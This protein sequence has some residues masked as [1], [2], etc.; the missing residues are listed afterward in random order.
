[1]GTR[2][3]KLGINRIE[4]CYLHADSMQRRRDC[5][6]EED[7]RK[8]RGKEAKRKRRYIEVNGRVQR[9]RNDDIFFLPSGSDVEFCPSVEAARASRRA[10]L[11]MD[12][13]KNLPRY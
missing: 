9:H 3:S 2:A 6:E 10:C 11:G 8:K 1:M 5:W 12:R 13:L 7:K 4:H